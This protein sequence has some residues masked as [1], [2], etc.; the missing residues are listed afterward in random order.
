[1]HSNYKVIVKQVS[2]SSTHAFSI[3]QKLV[4]H[5]AL[6]ILCALKAMIYELIPE[7]LV[8][9]LLESL[10]LR[11]SRDQ[12][13]LAMTLDCSEQIRCTHLPVRSMVIGPGALSQTRV[14]RVTETLG[15]VGSA[16]SKR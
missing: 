3:K 8:F 13:F 4:F 12:A 7:L 2:I 16:G 5:A 6:S 11:L 10:K 9:T 14:S 15:T 1:M